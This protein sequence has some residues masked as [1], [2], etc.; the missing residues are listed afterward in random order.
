M[1]STEETGELSKALGF[2]QKN[3][4]YYAQAKSV[5]AV[6][7]LWSTRS[8]DYY[9]VDPAET[10]DWTLATEKGGK[11]GRNVYLA[12]WRGMYDILLRAHIPFDIITDEDLTVERLK[13]YKTIVMANTP[14]MSDEECAA[15]RRYVSEGGGLVCSYETSLYD[16]WGDKRSDFGLKEVIGAGVAAGKD[17]GNLWKEYNHFTLIKTEHPI[18][19]GVRKSM[20]SPTFVQAIKADK[21][22]EVLG[23]VDMTNAPAE[24]KG[25]RYPAIIARQ[26]GRG[27]VVY[28]AGCLEERYWTANFSEIKELIKN[29]VIWTGGDCLPVEIK[30]PETVEVTLSRQADKKRYI[31]HFINY[32]GEMARPLST[33]IPIS[34]IQVVLKGLD[35][36]RI[37]TAKTL[38]GKRELTLKVIDGKPCFSLPK[39]DWYEAVILE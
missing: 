7:L 1:N 8:G 31:L 2:F 10:S 12:S 36:Q 37:R 19:Q 25:I 6:A 15:L 34:D 28:T 30:A 27:R 24:D 11:E 3:E 14:V 21:E 39:L 29:S 5:A 4:D 38:V 33:I 17:F 18:V 16:E 20:P 35:L 26:Y 23:I 22:E 13:R 32:T 9:A